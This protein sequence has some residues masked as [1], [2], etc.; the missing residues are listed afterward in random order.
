[1]D[2]PVA[3]DT[4]IGA[5]AVVLQIP[6]ERHREIIEALRYAYSLERE[7]YERGD[8]VTTWDQVYEHY[9]RGFAEQLARQFADY[10]WEAP[11]ARLRATH[12]ATVVPDSVGVIELRQREALVAWIAPSEFRLQ[13]EL[14]RCIL[15][16]L[17][18]HDERWIIVQRDQ[19]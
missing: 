4:A 3:T 18:R 17:E 11:A 12:M 2:T 5:C 6:S 7:L 16:R 10:S 9:R 15:D 8:S 1:V 14:P 13:W 19:Q